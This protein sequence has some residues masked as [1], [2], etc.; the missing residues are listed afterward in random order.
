MRFAVAAE[1]SQELRSQGLP[2]R[3]RPPEVVPAG[4]LHAL[5][6]ATKQAA[7]DLPLAELVPFMERDW[8]QGLSFYRRCP[9]CVQ[10]TNFGA[11]AE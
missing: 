10:A 8:E 6:V 5:D 11:A 4:V 9:A 1:G 3:N 7:G 2:R